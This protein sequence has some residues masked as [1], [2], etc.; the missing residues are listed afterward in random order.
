MDQTYSAMKTLTGAMY[1]IRLVNLPNEEFYPGINQKI[2]LEIKR[3]EQ[4]YLSHIIK[5]HQS[6]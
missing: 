2:S 4:S 1:S 6:L 3:K 5:K